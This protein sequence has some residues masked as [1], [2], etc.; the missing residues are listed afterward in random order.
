[1]T[2]IK[3]LKGYGI[4]IRQNKNQIHLTNGSDPFTNKRETES[5]Y[6]TNLPYEKIVLCGK[7]YISTEALGLLCENNK[8]L[9]LCDTY[10]KPISYMNPIMES[11][12]DTN[13][14]FSKEKDLALFYLIFH[15]LL[16]K[17]LEKR[18]V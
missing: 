14:E 16:S 9:I 11:Q 2:N 18:T 12:T 1:M 13:H 4:S 17:G 5:Y 10:G 7:G 6:I 15:P 3:F 8:N